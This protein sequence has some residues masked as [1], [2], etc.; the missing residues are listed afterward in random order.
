MGQEDGGAPVAGGRLGEQEALQQELADDMLLMA[1]QLGSNARA[2]QES[3]GADSHALQGVE[4]GVEQLAMKTYNSAVPAA[5][6][7]P[8]Q[9]SLQC[10]TVLKT[11]RDHSTAPQRAYRFRP[12]RP[13]WMAW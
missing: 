12:P 3:M 9:R 5:S 11:L 10:Q 7:A 2:F 8:T 6:A 13:Q 4:E 1:R